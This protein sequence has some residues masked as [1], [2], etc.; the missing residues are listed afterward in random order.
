MK[1]SKVLNENYKI[2]HKSFSSAAQEAVKMATKKGYEVDQDDFESE[3]TMGGR[4]NRARPGVGKTHEFKVGL[5]R[6]GK[7]VK[8][9]LV[10]QVYGMKNQ[11]ELNAYIS[12]GRIMKLSELLV[13]KVGRGVDPSSA[14]PVTKSNQAWFYKGKKRDI[15]LATSKISMGA[16][17]RWSGVIFNLDTDY[18]QD[19]Q[20]GSWSKQDKD[21]QGFEKGGWR[22]VGITSKLKSQ[23]A[24][25][26]NNPKNA[27]NKKQMP[28]VDR[29]ILRKYFK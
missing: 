2:Y 3:V 8:N 7:P 18:F 12:Q 4:Y 29:E 1:L 25:I 11:F 23:L 14:K 20:T 15:F 28:K 17:E 19:F 13:E 24:D 10:F 16:R 5:T 6:R 21:K 27:S 22:A 9:M 26:W